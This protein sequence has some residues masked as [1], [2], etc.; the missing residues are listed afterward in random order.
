MSHNR[1]IILFVASVVR[2]FPR[3]CRFLER[4]V[5]AAHPKSVIILDYP[6]NPKPRWT[7]AQPHEILSNIIGRNREI[8]IGHLET[9]RLLTE[10]LLEIPVARTQRT[11]NE[12]PN[13]ANGWMPALDGVALYGFIATYRPKIYLEIGSGNSTRFARKAITDFN[14]KTKIISIDPE[15]RSDI[16]KI[17]DEV[18][19]KPVEDVDI[20]FFDQLC[21]NDIL[22]IDNSHRSFMNS[23][24]TA[25][26]IDILPRLQRGV[27]IEM[28]DIT[29]P[30]D[31]PGEWSARHYSE[32]YLL[33]ASLLSEGRAYEIVL[34]NMFIAGDPE[35]AAILGPLWAHPSMQNVETHGCSFWLTKN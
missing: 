3:I 18:I 30:L 31:Y 35:L 24:V 19:R 4:I 28:H 10:K 1:L 15:P 33:A 26:F 32:Q 17:C 8:Y 11:L 21:A 20:T 13:W 16:D 22:Y 12:E 29:L 5:Q 6:I 7:A 9:F 14:L 27:L 23:D 25:I 34:P 2:K